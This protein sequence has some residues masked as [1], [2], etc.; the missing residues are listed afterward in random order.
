MQLHNLSAKFHSEYGTNNWKDILAKIVRKNKVQFHIFDAD[1]NYNHIESV[2]TTFSYQLYPIYLCLFKNRSHITV[3]SDYDLFCKTNS[4][5]KCFGCGKCFKSKKTYQHRCHKI[6]TCF[7]CSRPIYHS[8]FFLQCNDSFCDSEIQLPHNEVLNVC[9]KCNITTFSHTCSTFHKKVCSQGAK[10]DCCEK[11][12]YK[13]IFS[14]QEDLINNHICSS[15]KCPYCLGHYHENIES[16]HQCKFET[17]E[18][19]L[20]Y[21]T[22]AFFATVVSNNNGVDCYQCS[23]FDTCDFHQNLDS[24]SETEVIHT[25]IFVPKSPNTFEISHFSKYGIST[26]KHKL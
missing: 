22:L 11:F 23:I 6:K 8:S 19:K 17:F 15:K 25:S 26:K 20:G 24:K 12:Y 1:L 10:F 2:P 5:F 18:P 9:L 21:P 13:S 4:K 7:A 16:S 3:I 14:N